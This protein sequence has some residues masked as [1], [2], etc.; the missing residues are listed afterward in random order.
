[1][2]LID[3]DGV[4]VGQHGTVGHQ[5]RG[6]QGRVDHHHV[7]AGGPPTCD[8]GPAAFAHRTRLRPGA[9]VGGDRQHPPGGV[10]GVRETTPFAV[11]ER[12]GGLDHL[13][14]GAAILVEQG[15]GRLC[16][17]GQTQVVAATFEQREA[18]PRTMFV[19]H[20]GNGG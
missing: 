20:G 18:E 4:M 7:R 13:G 14:C 6:V 5:M 16:G 8:F 12:G 11:V 2:S 19:A 17:P 9:L 1:V 3:D 10:V 15:T